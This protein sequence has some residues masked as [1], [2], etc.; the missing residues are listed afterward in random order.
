M[1]W[2]NGRANAPGRPLNYPL[3]RVLPAADFDD[4][5]EEFDARVAPAFESAPFDGFATMLLL[6]VSRKADTRIQLHVTPTEGLRSS[7]PDKDNQGPDLPRASLSTPIG[8]PHSDRNDAY[9]QCQV[10]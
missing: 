2:E 10:C 5:L 6:P 7:S 1:M 9:R 3:P 8:V 4:L